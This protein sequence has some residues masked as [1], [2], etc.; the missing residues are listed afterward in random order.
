MILRDLVS[1]VTQGRAVSRLVSMFD[2]VE[3]LVDE[4]DRRR[5]LADDMD[6]DPDILELDHSKE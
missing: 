4:S 5:R 3:G 2:S 1:N 6:D